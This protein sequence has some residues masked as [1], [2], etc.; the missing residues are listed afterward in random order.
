LVDAGLA[1][2]IYLTT[3]PHDGGEPGTPW[4]TS[5]TPPPLDVVTRKEW[6]DG[7]S[8]IVFEHVLIARAPEAE[9]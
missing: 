3:T 9:R 5:A 4:Y 8:T 1:Q 7:R 2:D 6:R